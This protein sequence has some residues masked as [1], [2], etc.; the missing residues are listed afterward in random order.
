MFTFKLPDKIVAGTLESRKHSNS[1]IY[2]FSKKIR[3]DIS[4]E[5]IAEQWTHEMTSLVFPKNIIIINKQQY[6][7]RSSAAIVTGSLRA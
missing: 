2:S 5:S 4:C 1:F 3:F 7:K 6:L